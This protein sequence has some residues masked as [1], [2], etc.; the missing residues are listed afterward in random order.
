[1]FC[2]FTWLNN[3]KNNIENNI[4]NFDAT[5]D[6]INTAVKNIYLAD[7]DAIR[8]LNDVAKSLSAGGWTIPGNLN[9]S[10]NLNLLPPGL[11]MAYTGTNDP[12]GWLICNG[13]EISRT[14]YANLFAVI[15][16]QFGKGNGSTTF[17]IPNYQGAFLR[18][19]GTS[20]INGAY[21]SN[22]LNKYQDSYIQD[23]Q[24]GNTLYDPGHSHTTSLN[25]G[26]TF[27]NDAG[28]NGSAVWNNNFYFSIGGY[29]NDKGTYSVGGNTNSITTGVKINNGNINNLHSYNVSNQ[30]NPYNYSVNWIIKI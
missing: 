4:E 16:E 30:T 18:G 26:F 14:T 29:S 20:P 27:R 7:I 22:T 13:R 6:A 5:T 1:M 15:G 9:I 3:K 28:G 11:V 17:N 24:H 10:G 23:H 2:Y 12:I 21:I 8:N 19:N 25:N